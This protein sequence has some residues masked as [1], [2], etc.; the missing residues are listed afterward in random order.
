MLALTRQCDIDPSHAEA[1]I[2]EV[3]LAISK[4]REVAESVKISKQSI[5]T[6][7]KSLA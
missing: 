6:V 2:D 5:D 7:A 1:M 3:Y 4:W